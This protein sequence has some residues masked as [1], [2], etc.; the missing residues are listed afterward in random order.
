MGG[1][2]SAFGIFFLDMEAGSSNVGSLLTSIV[3]ITAALTGALAGKLWDAS[4]KRRDER[5]LLIGKYI[6]QLQ[7]SAD[8]LNSRLINIFEANGRSVMSELYYD[9]TM[10]YSF[11]CPIALE[12]IMTLD[13]IYP[14]IRRHDEALSEFL[15]N[16]RLDVRMKGFG[17]HRYDRVA[18]AECAMVR[19]SDV[20]RLATYFEFRE[21]YEAARKNNDEWLSSAL[22][23]VRSLPDL[24]ESNLRRRGIVTTVAAL[25]ELSKYAEAL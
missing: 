8:L 18:L 9:F 23:F 19:E 21:R 7:Y 20:Y 10:L 24:P 6:S 15:D 1:L 25:T 16:H 12:R 5:Q 2:P 3:A 11:A 22:Q 14:Q 17:F 13:G 4:S